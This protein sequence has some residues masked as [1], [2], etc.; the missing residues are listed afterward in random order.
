MYVEE[1][2]C[3]APVFIL[4]VVISCENKAGWYMSVRGGG[5]VA[6]AEMVYVACGNRVWVGVCIVVCVRA[7]G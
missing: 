2:N 1:T 3:D 7:W 6:V 4:C 5:V